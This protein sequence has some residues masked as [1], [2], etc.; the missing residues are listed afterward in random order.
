MTLKLKS[1]LLQT[2]MLF[3]VR[4][5]GRAAIY[6]PYLIALSVCP[7]H[8]ELHSEIGLN[9]IALW[10]SGVLDELRIIKK[11]KE[12]RKPHTAYWIICY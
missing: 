6:L 5:C 8:R 2:E 4:C 3:E 12:E 10:V 9:R 11:I 1:I 7:L